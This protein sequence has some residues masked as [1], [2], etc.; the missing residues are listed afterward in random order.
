MKPLIIA[1]WKCNPI[2]L[3]EAKELFNKIV[4]G[5]ENI[6][7]VEVVI[8]PP[9][10]YISTFQHFN[11]PTIKLGSQDCFWEE[12][13]AY[14]GEVSPKML[15]DLG[16]EYVILGH[17]ER[18]RNLGE[19]DEMINKKVKA[20]LSAGL[21]P[22]LCIGET[23]EQRE[24][25]KTEDILKEQIELGMSGILPDQVSKITIAYEPV[26]AISGGDPYKTEELP[27]PNGINKI[28][29]LIKN[30]FSETYGDKGLVKVIYGGS[31]NAANS[32]SFLEVSEGLLVGGA[33]LKAEEFIKI[34]KN[35]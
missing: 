34:I 13:G 29:S 10:T 31:A 3:T 9:F 5:V 2:T 16:C 14:T 35:I 18:R 33:S 1:N 20:A 17:S 27:T 23:K 8:C 6:E 19:T 4:K 25:G 30:I 22:I 32:K 11:N 21:L 7:S 15:K 26:W 24:S 28:F 12:K